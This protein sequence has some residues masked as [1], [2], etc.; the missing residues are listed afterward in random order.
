MVKL[1]EQIRYLFSLLLCNAGSVA[2]TSFIQ[3]RKI[4]K[5]NVIKCVCNMWRRQVV[6]VFLSV[7]VTTHHRTQ[8]EALNFVSSLVGLGHVSCQ[9]SQ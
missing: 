8:A 4:I 3:L 9:Y 2:K 6:F 5:I 1:R 7:A